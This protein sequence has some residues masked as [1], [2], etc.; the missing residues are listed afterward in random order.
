MQAVRDTELVAEGFGE[1]LS[2][3]VTGENSPLYTN[4]PRKIK[5]DRVAEKI[6]SR[7]RVVRK[8]PLVCGPRMSGWTDE[9]SFRE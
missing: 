3:G 5:I 1:A 7:V 2:A 6:F 8:E 4:Q 9:V